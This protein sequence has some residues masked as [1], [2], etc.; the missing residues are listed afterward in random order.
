MYEKFAVV[1]VTYNRMVLLKE[2]LECIKNQNSAPHDVIIIDNHSTDGTD[3]FLNSVPEIKASH[4]ILKR[5]D[6]NIGG[7]G[8]FYDGMK[9]AMETESD[10]FLLID[11][12]AMIAPDYLQLIAESIQKHPEVLAYSGTVVTDNKI[13]VDHRR[14]F[15]R[16]DIPVDE[17]EYTKK[18]FEYDLS[19]FC[20]AVVNR[21]IV[22][23]V[24]L[25]EKDFFIWFDDTEYSFRVMS[26]SKFI[27]VNSAI[28]NHKTKISLSVSDTAGSKMNWKNYYGLRNAVYSYRKHHMM[29]LGIRYQVL[30]W[31][32]KAF[33]DYL[34]FRIEKAVSG[35]NLKLVLT[36]ITDGLRGNLGV[37]EVYRP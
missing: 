18:E 30:R 4:W 21:K 15:N 20:G 16:E 26:M 6:Q 34:D 13:V 11:D 25:P 12:D 31:L 5:E 9:I 19:S 17:T 24:G 8:G 14:K 23:R 29:Y 7:S 35:Y 33:K 32:K 1:V 2:C 10:W 36:A 22:D 27:N 37:N 3:E 28:V